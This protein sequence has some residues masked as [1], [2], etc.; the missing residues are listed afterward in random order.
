[1]QTRAFNRSEDERKKQ[2]LEKNPDDD[3]F[4]RFVSNTRP[5]MDEHPAVNRTIRPA[6][7]AFVKKG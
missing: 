1:E 6:M 7:L 5:R 4:L 3:E 2:H